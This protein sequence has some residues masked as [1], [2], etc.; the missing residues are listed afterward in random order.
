MNRWPFRTLLCVLFLVASGLSGKLAFAQSQPSDAKPCK[1]HSADGR[2]KH[3]IQIIF[4]N[5]HLRRDNPNVPS[6]MEQMPHLLN[7]I[8]SKGTLDTN[9]HP[10]L[11]SHTADDE[12]TYLTGVYGDR[13]GIP[14]AN[15]FGVFRPDGS[16]ASEF[17]F[18]Y[19]TNHISDLDPSSLDTTYGMLSGDGKNAPA[20]WVPFTRAGC[21]V[22][23][24]SS[25][26]LAIETPSFD[27]PF[28][29]GPNSPEAQE[30]PGQQFNDFEGTAVHCA[31]GSP[32][33]SSANHGVAD[34]LPQEPGGY[35]GFNALYGPKYM[36]QVLGPI[37][38][39][40]GNPMAT[41]PGFSPTASQALG[42]LLTMQTSGIPV[43]L[44]YVAD[45][46]DSQIT[47]N[48]LGPGDPAYVVQNQ[49][50]DAAFDKFFTRLNAAGINQTN[51][52][53]IITADEGD[54]FVGTA[55]TP[56]NCDGVHIACQYDY[57]RVGE[58]DLNI[59]GLVAAQTGNTTPFDL[60]SD[61]APTIYVDG[62]PDRTSNAT[63]QL[64]RDFAKLTAL[65]P[66]TNNADHL[67]V[68]FADPA[69]MGLLHM[70][71]ADPARTPS[72]TMFGHHDYWFTNSGPITPVFDDPVNGNAWNHGGIQPEIAN[73]WL[74]MVGPG[75][76]KGP[77]NA[78]NGEGESAVIEFS[79]HTDVRPT[80]LALLG[81]RDD[82]SHDGRVLL[83]A[84][85]P[86]ALP[87]ALRADFD[88]LVRLGRVYKQINAPFGEL[89]QKTLNISTA[90]LVSNAPGDAVYTKLENKLEAWRDWRDALASQMRGILE[91]AAF[92]GKEVSDEKV[93][94]LIEKANALLGQVRACSADTSACA[95]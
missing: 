13:H 11:I 2:I 93:E 46:H 56:A 1:L 43:T 76:R 33:C 15:S 12:L 50:Y 54:H 44:A 72:F 95:N 59:N 31:K 92:R 29:F 77:D 87:V 53:F 9:H 82:Y 86:S 80:V 32:V 42:Y 14:V 16:V 85:H 60:H 65:N 10:V 48:G 57:T 94:D 70:I 73:T 75:I 58:L 30:T 38:D 79:D 74:G 67:A 62:N 34:V 71:T 39:L 63:R 24:I 90:A 61:M 78:D 64:E 37:L 47:G 91:G 68:A 89:A 22:G 5:V 4:D 55:P 52:L 45:L 36:N 21:D 35:T 83:E 23:V 17:S 84:L 28:I 18:F 49:S 26:N 51:T 27:V 7:F 40:D 20:P 3:V 25:A 69:E 8:R 81:L 6:D 41:F 66:I 19:W 88:K